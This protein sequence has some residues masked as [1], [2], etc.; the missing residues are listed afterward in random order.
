MLETSYIQ[1]NI[2]F[3][4]FKKLSEGTFSHVV[5][6]MCCKVQYHSDDPHVDLKWPFKGQGQGQKCKKIA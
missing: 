1:R 4:R 2:A 6:H 3:L 5:A